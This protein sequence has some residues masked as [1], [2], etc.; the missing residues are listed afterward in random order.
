ML[1]NE[2]LAE[3]SVP[4]IVKRVPGSNDTSL[5]T[6]IATVPSAYACSLHRWQ[7]SG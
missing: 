4:D 1:S 5:T 3:P 7:A 6:L 2:R